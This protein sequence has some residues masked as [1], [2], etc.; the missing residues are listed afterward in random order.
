MATRVAR[1]SAV[2]TDG[3]RRFSQTSW[4]VERDLPD[5]SIE[6]HRYSSVDEAI[7]DAAEDAPRHRW[8]L[9]DGVTVGDGRRPRWLL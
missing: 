2:S 4:I 9:A 6:F 1:R 8:Q 7:A 5:G 3:D